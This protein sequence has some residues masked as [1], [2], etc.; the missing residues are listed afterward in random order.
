ME[1]KELLLIAAMTALLAGAE[2]ASSSERSGKFRCVGVNSCK[3]TTEC[4]T[5]TNACK[6][7]NSC[8]GQG[9]L[10][11]KTAKECKTKGGKIVLQ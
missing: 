5:T 10:H 6:G 7:K 4:K 9:W 3:G 2:Q 8:R 1:K 11:T